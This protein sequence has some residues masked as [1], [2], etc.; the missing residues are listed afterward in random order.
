MIFL[1]NR[2]PHERSIQATHRFIVK[3]TINYTPKIG[4]VKQVSVLNK[5]IVHRGRAG[6]PWGKHPSKTP[7]GGS[8]PLGNPKI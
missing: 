1:P 4:G 3:P 2:I 8:V 5:H 6:K 7:Y